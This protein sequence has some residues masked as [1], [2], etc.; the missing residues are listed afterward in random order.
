MQDRESAVRT[1]YGESFEAG[2]L[3]SPAAE[4]NKEP[5]LAALRRLLPKTGTILE[6]ASGTGQ[7]AM[8]FARALP[9]LTWQPSDPDPEAL[10]AIRAREAATPLANVRLPLALDVLVTPWP[11]AR[12]DAILCIN[13]LHIAPW[14]AAQALFIHAGQLL[15]TGSLLILYGPFKRGGR[16]TA[17][18]NEAFDASLRSR[19]PEWGVRD[20]DDAALLAEAQGFQAAEVLEMP[21]NN[22][23][24]VFRKVA[25]S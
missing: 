5:I 1:H 24:V 8:H 14:A 11:I 20:L 17:P 6:L 15:A 10:A 18:S 19:D 22:V 2:I 13:M 4:R 12:A 9:K 21:A 3:E 25:G 16:H 7:H 23:L